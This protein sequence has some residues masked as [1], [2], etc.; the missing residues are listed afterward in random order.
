MVVPTKAQSFFFLDSS[1]LQVT[2][3]SEF[4][5]PTWNTFLKSGSALESTHWTKSLPP[6]FPLSG[7]CL[8]QEDLGTID[9]LSDG[10]TALVPG[11]GA[12]ASLLVL[13][14]SRC[15]LVNCRIPPKVSSVQCWER[16][17][18]AYR[19]KKWQLKIKLFSF[20]IH[21]V[22]DIGGKR[23]PTSFNN[24]SNGPSLLCQFH[25]PISSTDS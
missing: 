2:S 5:A 3:V 20:I 12:S 4:V 15:L 17:F 18:Q 7:N 23:N 19:G 11:S 8:I 10:P 25:R 14:H 1:G 22:S 16:M 9:V 13:L 6:N 24:S 21:L